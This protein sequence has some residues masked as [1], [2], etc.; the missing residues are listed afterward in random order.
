MY[1]HFD[2]LYNAGL[3]NN[4]QRWTAANF[5]N[6][7]IF[8]N[9]NQNVLAYDGTLP[10]YIL[11]GLN[12]DETSWDIVTTFYNHVILAKGNTLRGSDLNDATNWIPVGET[13]G[14]GVVHL[15][16][17]MVQ[18]DANAS[19][20]IEVDA[21]PTGWAVGTF[22]SMVVAS[23]KTVNYYSVVGL[24]PFTDAS[25]I[26]IPGG[27]TVN[28]SLSPI[29]IFIDT[30]SN[31]EQ[32][33]VIKADS[34]TVE[35]TVIS[36][37]T[38]EGY[39]GQ[40]TTGFTM[41]AVG[42]TVA[43]T[44]TDDTLVS[45]GDY[46]NI[47]PNT[48]T[49]A[50][51]GQDIYKVVSVSGRN[52]VI[53]R[54]G[55][56]SNQTNHT[57]GD[58]IIW[59]PAIIVS[60]LTS[61]IA[62]NANIHEAYKVTLN[63]VD[64]IGCNATGYSFTAGQ[65]IDPLETNEAWQY[66]GSGGADAGGIKALFQLGTNLY[67]CRNRSIQTMQYSGRPEIYTIRDEIS[68]EG[69]LGKYL[70]VKV[71]NDEAYFWGHKE[72]YRLA[73][74]QIQPVAQQVSKR[75]LREEFVPSALDTYLMYHNEKDK[76]IWTIYGSQTVLDVP[77]EVA[78]PTPPITPASIAIPTDPTTYGYN[79]MM[80]H[81]AAS[82]Q[83]VV[84][85]NI[86]APWYEH[87][88]YLFT[89]GTAKSYSG[90]KPS[91]NGSWWEGTWTTTDSQITVNIATV[92]G[93]YNLIKP[94][95]L[96]FDMNTLPGWIY[97]INSTN[98]YGNYG[99]WLAPVV[100]GDGYSAILPGT[101]IPY[102]YWNGIPAVATTPTKPYKPSVTQLVPLKVMI[103]NYIENSCV[104]DEW[105][106]A[107]SG[108]S[109]IGGLNFDDGSRETIVGVLN[110]KILGTGPGFLAYG[111]FNQTPIYNNCGRAIQSEC[112]TADLDF[113]DAQSWKYIDTLQLSLY[114]KDPNPLILKRPFRLY[115]DFGSKENLDGQVTWAKG[116][117]VD[118]SGNGNIITSVNQRISGRYICLKF[119]SEQTDIQWRLASYTLSGRKGSTY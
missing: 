44:L 29:A 45:A 59:Q 18:P 57:A 27:Q 7:I 41:P 36:N 40:F 10:L 109:A 17:T 85:L 16:G 43:V 104:F 72:M 103:Y 33:A 102:K 48:T 115:V 90:V 54:M 70:W 116:Q 100:G 35:Y 51:V 78:L 32:G 8:A 5:Y 92:G 30:I 117:W 3:A 37:S 53:Q 98:N 96:T 105:D 14:T 89:D 4:T 76:E 1:L 21:L 87:F 9:P 61:V 28:V 52:L 86:S 84:F 65:E 81:T 113:E 25:A 13:S 63:R 47:A 38:M 112:V 80:Q 106:P 2:E 77:L 79:I 46:I 73:G 111:E 55:I 20:T 68:D 15:L 108:I 19:V 22:V 42:S 93:P 6:K 82:A 99:K 66:R 114:I 110:N 69:L 97:C 64:T 83:G 75:M 34:G 58:N 24:S 49:Q 88:G 26:G 11:P 62:A 56:G 101:P 67:I 74:G 91:G 119:R 39:L 107:L 23:T 71:G 118:V 50:T 95:I 12:A 94:G 31:F 60:G